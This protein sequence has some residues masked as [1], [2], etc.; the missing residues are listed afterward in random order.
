[1]MEQLSL[2]SVRKR[3]G[4]WDDA[5]EEGRINDPPPGEWMLSEAYTS[6]T[7]RRSLSVSRALLRSTQ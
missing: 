6:G 5:W 4:E 2:S 1:M 7:L 3:K